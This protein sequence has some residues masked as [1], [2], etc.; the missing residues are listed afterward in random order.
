MAHRFF[1]NAH[2]AA[3]L[4][5][6]ALCVLFVI[7]FPAEIRSQDCRA[8]FLSGE[9]SYLE[10]RRSQDRGAL[11]QTINTL[12]PC[13]DLPAD[14]IESSDVF[15][16]LWGFEYLAKSQYRLERLDEQR[17]SEATLFK[18]FALLEKEGINLF[19]YTF[20]TNTFDEGSLIRE[21]EVFRGEVTYR[22][23]ADRF[24]NPEP[25]LGHTLMVERRAPAYL[26][27][28]PILT[29]ESNFNECLFFSQQ[30]SPTMQPVDSS[31]C[32]QVAQA[33]AST[34]GSLP[35][36]LAGGAAVAGGVAC[37]IYCGGTP[38]SAD[39]GIPGPPDPR[40]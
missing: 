23:V 7:V 16:A 29:I 25:L 11:E 10:Y 31:I 35:W 26:N 34:G 15:F 5:T 36:Y 39:P 33:E 8:A 9:R 27:T 19:T 24:P 17:H 14:S 3:H 4:L 18:M 1:S 20:E 13:S 38:A 21:F 28:A 32:K 40:N 6:S 22:Y 30:D 2:G 37:L 12:Q